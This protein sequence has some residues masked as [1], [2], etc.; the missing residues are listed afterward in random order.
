[1]SLEGKETTLFR[2]CIDDNWYEDGNKEIAVND[3]VDS[4]FEVTVMDKN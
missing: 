3:V 4:E 1:V 2:N